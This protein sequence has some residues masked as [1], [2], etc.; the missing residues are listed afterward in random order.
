M[1]LAGCVPVV[2]SDLDVERQLNTSMP[3]AP[4]VSGGITGTA[5]VVRWQWESAAE[6]PND[7][8][9]FRWRLNRGAWVGP[10]TYTT[11]S[12]VE[13]E[14]GYSDHPGV[15]L[16]DGDG[17]KH[18]APGTYRLD[19]QERDLSGNWSASTEYLVVVPVDVSVGSVA[20]T[21]E[22][23]D[24]AEPAF[25]I[26][27]GETIPRGE[28]LIVALTGLLSD[29][30]ITWLVNGVPVEGEAGEFGASVAIETSGLPL[31]VNRLTVLLNANGTVYS[32]IV[33]FEVVEL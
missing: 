33:T 5:S 24:S 7:Q 6:E 21:V 27:G 3:V 15:P 13:G 11:L 9:V 10:L 4:T 28:T 16:S 30:D 20:I 12:P 29:A 14:S 23:H 31:G 8:P 25:E 22:L 26:S 2:V 17:T 19:V 1:V 32:T 18:S